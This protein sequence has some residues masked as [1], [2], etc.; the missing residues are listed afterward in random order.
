MDMHSREQY[1]AALRE[2]YRRAGKKGKT[3]L[4]NEARR[5][6]RLSRKVLIRKLAHP[7]APPVPRKRR[8]RAAQYG[9]E[10]LAPLVRVWE[11]FDYPCGQRLVAVLR[12]Q[13]ARLRQM[14]EL[15]CSD[16]VVAKLEQMS[17]KTADRLLSRERAVRHL[18]RGRSAPV[19]PLL[20]QRIPVKTAG[21]WDRSQVG[22]V[23]ADFVLH[24]GRSTAGEYLL[25]LSVTDIA[26]GWWE[27]E[28]QMGRSQRATQE[29]LKAIR[30]R[31]PF[32]LCELH[33]DNDSAILNELLWKYCRKARIRMSRSRPYQ[34]NDNAWVEQKN[35]THIRKVVGYRRYDTAGQQAGLRELY[36]LLADYKNFFQPAMKLKE[37]VRVAGKVHRV[38]DE[39]K[40][41]YQRLLDSGALSA[42]QR[43]ELER[44]Y[45][46]LNPAEMKR[47][48]EQLRDR[49]FGLAEDR[50]EAPARRKPQWPLE[51]ASQ[52]NRRL[53]AQQ[54]EA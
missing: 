46:S 38:Y 30:G 39:P 32:R 16:E 40:T 33:P 6:T 14:G 49:L 22:N 10:V 47:R 11:I 27:G 45:R 13:V 42:R 17:A 23:Q 1:L 8:R 7:P 37:K 24:G 52:R 18:K 31:L 28:P 29:G 4:L 51:L 44:R 5:R 2:E 3:R 43:R 26:S 35:W 12:E 41:P 50:P 54:A 25:T 34:K 48:I 9:V 20:Y 21:E 15:R 53:R 19:H 36:R